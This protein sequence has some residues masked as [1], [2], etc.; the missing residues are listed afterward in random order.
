MSLRLAA[1]QID[2]I[3]QIAGD[4]KHVGLG[5]DFDGGIGLQSV[6]AEIDTIADLS[7]LDTFLKE[8]GYDDSQI[9]DIHYRNFL[10]MIQSVL[11]S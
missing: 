7:K 3:C 4:S 9:K 11:P 2:T 5:T 6:P 10:D 8:M 1:E